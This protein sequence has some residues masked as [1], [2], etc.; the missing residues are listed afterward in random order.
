MEVVEEA[1]REDEAGEIVAVDS[2]EEAPEQAQVEAAL[3]ELPKAV[4]SDV[5]CHESLEQGYII[6]FDSVLQEYQFYAQY[7]LF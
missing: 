4:P 5:I 7:I 2:P 6:Q 3:E 1:P